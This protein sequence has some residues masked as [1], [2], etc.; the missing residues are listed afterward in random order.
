MNTDVWVMQEINNTKTDNLGIPLPKGRVRFYRRDTDGA[1]EF[2][3]ENEIKHTPLDET[4]RI[5]TGNAFDIVGERRQ[6][7]Y[8]IDLSGHKIDESFEIKIRNHKKEPVKVILKENLY[9]WSQWEI[10]VASQKFQKHN[11]R[12]IHIPIEVAAD[13]E[14]IV[15]Y[16]VK[17]SW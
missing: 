17:Y 5:P 8:Q 1:L 16:T 3:G 2:V 15:T 11:S 14:K 6:T 7:N 12:T 4:L 13:Q 9:R 10:T